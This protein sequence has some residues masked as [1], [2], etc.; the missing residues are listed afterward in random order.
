MNH[1]LR[2]AIIALTILCAPAFARERGSTPFSALLPH[3]QSVLRA[4]LAVR[5]EERGERDAASAYAADALEGLYAED[6]VP[7]EAFAYVCLRLFD[8][9]EERGDFGAA[10]HDCLDGFEERFAAAESWTIAS[11]FWHLHNHP[12]APRRSWAE[13]ESF[14]R[15]LSPYDQFFMTSS[16]DELFPGGDPDLQCRTL[17]SGGREAG[18]TPGMIIWVATSLGPSCYEAQSSVVHDELVPRLQALLTGQPQDTETAYDMQEVLGTLQW[19]LGQAP[20]VQVLVPV[21]A[22]YGCEDGVEPECLID[23]LLDTPIGDDGDAISLTARSMAGL[24]VA[25]GTPVQQGRARQRIVEAMR[26]ERGNRTENISYAASVEEEADNFMVARFVDEGNFERARAVLESG[27]IDR[28]ALASALFRPVMDVTRDIEAESGKAE[29]LAFLQHAL[30]IENNPRV[31]SQPEQSAMPRISTQSMVELARGFEW[32][33]AHDLAVQTLVLA[34]WDSALAD[35]YVRIGQGYVLIGEPDLARASFTQAAGRADGDPDYEVYI[36]AIA[37][38]S[39]I[40]PTALDLEP[41]GGEEIRLWSHFHDDP[42][43]I[44]Y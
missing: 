19:E 24:A 44:P 2:V 6:E 7:P 8:L 18:F 13:I 4:T 40:P 28:P 39:T 31:L 29:A 14:W 17:V 34:E 15:Q 23:L 10:A 22:A 26:Q 11:L 33:G 5:A 36:A 16:F 32:L 35:D 12:A 43:F 9:S 21:V 41:L 25:Y 30:P 3:E 20:S 37:S 42:I 27:L 1:V 38:V